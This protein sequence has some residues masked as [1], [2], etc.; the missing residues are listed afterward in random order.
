ML[1]ITEELLV[2]TLDL[3]HAHVPD[4]IRPRLK[5]ALGGALLAQLL[6]AGL[7]EINDHQRVQVIQSELS[8][9]PIIDE[10]VQYILESSSSR[11]VTHWVRIFSQRTKKTINALIDR[12]CENHV[13][14][15]TRSSYIWYVPFEPA[16]PNV[17]SAKYWYKDKLRQVVL[18]P[19]LEPSA[20]EMLLLQLIHAADL[21]SM[22]FTRDE[23]KAVRQWI[24]EKGIPG[25][26]PNA[27]KD[28]IDEEMI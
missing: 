10:A 27:V 16:L 26:I 21:E 25:G 2:L 19:D 3:K 4:K 13:L 9:D 8:N 20:H 22:V 15:I 7:I 11:K 28:V 18:K 6:E 17:V 14:D 12:L 24:K 23:R 5:Y 1:S